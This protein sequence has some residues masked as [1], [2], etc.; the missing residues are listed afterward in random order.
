MGAIS[1]AMVFKAS[2]RAHV[3]LLPPSAAA[4]AATASDSKLWQTG[5]SS[6]GSDRYGSALVEVLWEKNDWRECAVE[7]CVC[8]GGGGGA[9]A[10]RK[11]VFE[12]MR[13]WRKEALRMMNAKR[14]PKLVINN[15]DILRKA[16]TT[17]DSMVPAA[18]YHDSFIWRLIALGVNERCLPVILSTSDGYYS[19]QAFVDFGFP[20]VFLSRETFGWTVQEAKLHMVTEYFSETEWKVIDEVLGTNPRHLSELYALKQSS[21]YPEMLQDRSSFEDIVD[22][23]LAYLQVTVVNPA[24]ESALAILQKFAADVHNG[25]IP[26]S[27]LQYGAPWRHPPSKDDPSATFKWAKIQL[28]DFVQSFVNTEFGM[29]YLADYSL[30]ILDD[31][32]A[33]AMMEVGLLYVQR[34]PS[35]I[36]P[37]TRGIQ[38]CLTRWN[39]SNDI[40][41][42]SLNSKDLFNSVLFLSCI[43]YSSDWSLAMACF[44]K[45][46]LTL[47]PGSIV[48]EAANSRRSFKGGKEL[49]YGLEEAKKSHIHMKRIGWS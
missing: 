22:A 41:L 17:D 12:T 4:Q 24:I 43:S 13:E 5:Q 15:I 38:R 23:Y 40:P 19:Y 39:L 46:A 2:P 1:S 6:I 16:T 31:P 49:G 10:L 47:L 32:S 35:F 37:I 11:E 9:R 26:E 48:A 30:E 20:H 8:E 33:V 29:N 36:R 45:L 14:E 25:K 44:V 27:R 18:M 42:S 21:N 34:D 7:E 28:M 3:M